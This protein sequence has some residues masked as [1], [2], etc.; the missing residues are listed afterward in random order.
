M[1]ASTTQIAEIVKA[2]AFCDRGMSRT[3]GRA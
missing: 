1:I 3:G 2:I